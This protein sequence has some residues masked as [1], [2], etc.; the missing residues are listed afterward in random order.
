MSNKTTLLQIGNAFYRVEKRP[1]FVAKNI[2]EVKMVIDSKK[3]NL[4]L[5]RGKDDS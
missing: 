1:Y 4:I 3:F 5:P 2:A